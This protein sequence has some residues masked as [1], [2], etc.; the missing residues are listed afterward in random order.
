MDRKHQET[1]HLFNRFAF[2]WT[3]QQ[4]QSFLSP[5]AA[6]K[7]LWKQD[8]YEP[9]FGEAEKGPALR[10]IR[11]MSDEEK[12]AVLKDQRK[13]VLQLNAAWIDHMATTEAQ[14]RE[15]MAFFWHDHFACKLQNPQ[16][17]IGQVN[18][19][20]QHAL[21]KFGDLLLAISRDPGMIYFLNNQQNR[22]DHPNENFA[23]ELM[24][25]FTL[26]RGYY[27]EQDVQ[28]AARAFTGWSALP[29]GT[30]IFRRRQHDFGT[31]T[32]LGKRGNFDGKDIIDI[33]LEQPQTARYL[34]A[35][36]YRFW[37]HE[38][39]PQERWESLSKEF[40]ESDYDIAALMRKVMAADWFYD[41]AVQGT[42]IKSPVEYIVGTMR[43]LDLSFAAPESPFIL[44]K[45]LGQVLLFPPN[46][47]GWPEGK[48]WI[49]SST[50]MARLNLPQVLVGQKALQVE[51]KA[52]FAGN[53]EAAGNL[54]GLGRLQAQWDPAALEAAIQAADQPLAWLHHFLLSLP[55]THLPSW[56]APLPE[57]P[58]DADWTGILLQIIQSPEYQLC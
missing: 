1:R 20:R 42:R 26:G 31:K 30:F 8:T 25:L 32:F 6:S 10:D 22:K 14:L 55:A 46:V 40:Y 38:D 28:E 41:P 51:P 49:D 11:M 37:V 3:P 45:I 5:E 9:L 50:L 53:E 24:E 2:G 47:S 35:K 29:N 21:G 4:A 16:V 43:A 48:A 7:A 15:K 27:T 19:L 39:L 44:Q 54:R 12:K 33:L 34:T 57:D 18:T 58:A 36:M 52:A 23:R 13:H 56:Q 17:A